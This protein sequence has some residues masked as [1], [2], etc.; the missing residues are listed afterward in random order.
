MALRLGRVGKVGFERRIRELVED[1][2]DLAIIAVAMLAVRKAL[3]QQLDILN[4]QLLTVVRA[5]EVCRRLMTIPGVGPVV[6][7]TFR[8]TVDVPAR[9]NNSKKVGAAFG[10]AAR[11]NQSGESISKCGDAMMCVMLH[12]AAQTML[13]RSAKW[14]WLK[15]WALKIAARPPAQIVLPYPPDPIMGGPSCRS[16]REAR[17]LQATPYTEPVEPPEN[18]RPQSAN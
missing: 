15:A 17:T 2:S 10:L 5:D 1:R 3:R 6:A 18:A 9:F 4:T 16:R 13:T 11:Q 7:L 12:E 8:T 14:S